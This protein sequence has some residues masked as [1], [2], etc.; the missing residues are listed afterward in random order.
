MALGG[1]ADQAVLDAVQRV[2]LREH[3][4]VQHLHVGLGERA[5]GILHLL[6]GSFHAGRVE[7]DMR[8]GGR[9]GQHAIEVVGELGHFHQSLPA[10]G[11]AA[12]PIRVLRALA[13]VGLDQSLRLDDRFVYRAPAE[14]D[15][16]FRMPESEHAV[17]ALM[18]GVGGSGGISIAQRRGHLREADDAG[19]AA[20]AHHFEF[21]IPIF[22]G[23]PQFHLDVGVGGGPQ[24]GGDAAMG[25]EH[26]RA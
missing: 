8:I 12:V 6:N 11:G 5:A 16:L 19:P 15:D 23:Q 9:T 13:I 10:A 1:I 26:L 3:R 14:I 18:A 24:R 20:I 22:D 7:M 21:A 2:A 25:W 4:F 17:A